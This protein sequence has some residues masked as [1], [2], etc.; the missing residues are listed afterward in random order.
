MLIADFET[1][2]YPAVNVNELKKIHPGLISME[3]YFRE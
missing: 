1:T 2:G 3:D